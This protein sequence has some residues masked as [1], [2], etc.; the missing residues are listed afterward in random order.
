MN[1]TLLPCPRN[2]DG[3]VFMEEELIDDMFGSADPESGLQ[4]RT[5]AQGPR[6][7]LEVPI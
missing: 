3:A 1:E 7:I 2:G 6:P 4:H 5:T